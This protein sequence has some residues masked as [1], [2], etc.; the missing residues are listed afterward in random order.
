MPKLLRDFR[1]H[2]C[3]LITE[4]FIDTKENHTK[5]ENCGGVAT[6]IIA[7]PTVSLDGTDPGFPGAYEKWA[8]IREQNAR[9][10]KKRSYAEP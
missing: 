9:I 6:R 10:K 2:E 8:N 7:I 3:G 5:C 4:R 1:C